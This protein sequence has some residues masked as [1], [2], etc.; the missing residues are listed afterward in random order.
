MIFFKTLLDLNCEDLL[1]EL[2]FKHLLRGKHLKKELDADISKQNQS[3][4]S[5]RKNWLAISAQKLLSSSVS[6]YLTSLCPHH[7][8]NFLGT[9]NESIHSFESNISGNCKCHLNYFGN[10][11][12]Y[13]N[14]A[15][16]SIDDCCLSTK[17]WRN[18]YLEPCDL[19][20]KVDDENIIFCTIDRAQNN[21]NNNNNDE[22]DNNNDSYCHPNDDTLDINDIIKQNSLMEKLTPGFKMKNC[23]YDEKL[24][25]IHYRIE[26]NR[27]GLNNVFHNSNHNGQTIDNDYPI[28]PFLTILFKRFEKFFENEI[29]TNLHLT[30]L[31]TR[32]CHFPHKL[33]L[34][35]LFDETLSRTKNVPCF[36]HILQKLS[37]EAQNYCDEIPN[38]ES[39]IQN[40]K[41]NLQSMPIGD[42]DC[43]LLNNHL[44][45]SNV[46][47][48]KSSESDSGMIL[49]GLDE[50]EY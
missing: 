39:M 7:S 11:L 4:Q 30:G 48:A 19:L 15:R 21:N 32:L 31:I 2:I 41:D 37:L 3:Y 25:K 1:Y 43:F 28:G 20:N 8:G 27:F 13:V 46:S 50:F 45:S 29:L 34:S 35:L 33:L 44:R 47:L 38:F 49:I 40:A 22:K 24:K 18:L 42:L 6:Y 12:D 9:D 26:S 16:T 10:Y 5:Y 17:L 23:Y 14:D 36:I